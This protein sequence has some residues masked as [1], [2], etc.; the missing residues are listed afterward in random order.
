MPQIRAFF[1]ESWLLSIYQH[2]SGAGHAENC[3]R[4]FQAFPEGGMCLEGLRNIIEDS[5]DGIP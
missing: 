4:V 2:T 5:V 3:V 1:P